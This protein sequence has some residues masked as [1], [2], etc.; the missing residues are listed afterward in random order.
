MKERLLV[1]QM[2]SCVCCLCTTENQNLDIIGSGQAEQFIKY[3]HCL[4]S[5]LFTTRSGEFEDSE[6]MY[7]FMFIM[8]ERIVKNRSA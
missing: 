8:G 1:K 7:G 2:L 4:N 5:Q 3:M 6:T